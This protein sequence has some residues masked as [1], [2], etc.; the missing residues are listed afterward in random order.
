MSTRIT[1]CQN[2]IS[3]Q[4]KNGKS[5]K[6]SLT[7]RLKPVLA[8]FTAKRQVKAHLACLACEGIPNPIQMSKDYIKLLLEQFQQQVNKAKRPF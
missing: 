8:T 7:A 4:A 5:Y 1:S 6:C 3:D 2:T